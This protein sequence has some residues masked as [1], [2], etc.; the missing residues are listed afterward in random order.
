MILPDLLHTNCPHTSALPVLIVSHITIRSYSSASAK[1]GVASLK[2]VPSSCGRITG[3][4]CTAT[5]PAGPPNNPRIVA[6]LGGQNAE[7]ALSRRSHNQ[8]AAG[9]DASQLQTPPPPRSHAC[10]LRHPS[11]GYAFFGLPHRGQNSGTLEERVRPTLH[12][13]R[14]ASSRSVPCLLQQKPR[15]IP[16]PAASRNSMLQGRFDG[17]MDPE[18]ERST[19][20]TL[21]IRQARKPWFSREQRW[22]CPTMSHASFCE[23]SWKHWSR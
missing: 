8:T 7:G 18:R 13:R 10:R 4:I 23:G 1:F 21:Y 15:R 19:Q 14:W 3:Q 6:T 5:E 16:E 11:Y 17:R 22:K 9:T 12:H 20:G 2:L